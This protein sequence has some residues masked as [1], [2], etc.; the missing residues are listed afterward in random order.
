MLK[1][2]I[3]GCGKIADS[4]AAQIKRIRYCELV[5]VCDREQLLAQQLAERF[6]VDRY[7]VESSSLLEACRPDVV[8]ITTPP[9]SH[10]ELAKR[11]LKSGSHVYVEKPFTVDCRE[12]EELLELANRNKRLITAGHNALFTSAARRMRQLIHEGY[13][14]GPP[15]HMES[16]WCYDLSDPAY[17]KAALGDRQHWLRRL[18][19]KLLQNIISHGVAPLAE[20][21]THTPEE[22]T[23]CGFVSPALRSIGEIDIVDELRVMM[24]GQDQT[25]YFTFSSQMRPSQHEFRAF[26]SRNGIVF[27]EDQQT[28]IKLR[29]SRRKSYAEI[30]IPPLNLARQYVGNWMHNASLFLRND[31]HFDASKKYL[32]ESF[33]QSIL[34]RLPPP[35]PYRDIMLTT[36]IMEKIFQQLQGERAQQV[37][38]EHLPSRL[39]VAKLQQ[40]TY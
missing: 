8:H 10:F 3:V 5:A 16:T 13:L 32:F 21:F 34:K 9:Q 19:G 36:E 33:Y 37:N 25:A 18:P 28:V 35:V 2:A 12:A 14:G 6:G 7:F 40:S 26:G 15:V 4:H 31:F 11:C 38:S 27:D 20:F 30:F 1:I 22:I 17:A 24:R 29:G 23:V 39:A